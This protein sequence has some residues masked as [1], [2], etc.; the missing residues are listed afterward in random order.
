LK[1]MTFGMELIRIGIIRS[2]RCVRRR[3]G[4]TIICIVARVI[5]V[6]FFLFIA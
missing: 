6:W 2:T 4:I 1:L 3:R 5:I